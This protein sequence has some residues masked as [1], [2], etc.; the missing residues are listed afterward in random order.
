MIIQP[1]VWGFICAS[2]HPAG[3]EKNVLDQIAAVPRMQGNGPRRALIVG[4]STGYGLAARIAAAFGYGASTL[5]VFLE[6]PG[7]DKRPASA[8]WY[9][10][11]AFERAAARAGL[12]SLSL[13]ADAFSHAARERAIA[14]IREQMD[15][16]ID[17]LVYSLAAP[18]RRLPDSGEVVHTALKP[19]GAAFSG[20]TID[21]DH[22][23]LATVTVEAA[24]EAEIGATTAVMGGEDWT[25]WVNALADAGVLAPD[26]KAVAFS[27]VGPEITWPIYRH[28]TIG[29]AKQH[30]EQTAATL[31]EQG[32]DARVAVMKFIVSQASAAIPVIPLYASLALKV[33]RERGLDESA[34]EQQVRLFRD[35][36]YRTDG[37]APALDADGLL[38]L[39]DREL[40]ADV[41]DA[42]KALW[43]RVNDAN[44]AELTDYARYKREFL[45]L[46]GFARDDVDYAAD[47]APRVDF[48]PLEL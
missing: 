4:A 26:A 11:A 34:I 27:Y 2:A 20:T 45:R 25:L 10:A 22:D 19:I 43:P 3:C 12:H 39:D 23:K 7:K 47:V 14:L 48:A 46:F 8:G 42:C 29:R 17:L 31:R 18:A 30:L 41:Q 5:G 13:N 9:N 15:G 1:K 24:S 36:L 37:A 16:P 28:G 33:M 21:T 40:R 38:R 32:V 35:F 44:L 6:K